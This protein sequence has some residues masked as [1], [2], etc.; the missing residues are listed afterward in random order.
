MDAELRDALQH[1]EAIFRDGFNKLDNKV[2]ALREAVNRRDIENA[3]KMAVMSTSLSATHRR[4][5]AHETHHKEQRGRIAALIITVL[6]SFF[7]S[8]W[9]WIKSGGKS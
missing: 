8:I 9:A 2:D 6:G 1:Q 7:A 5:D 4:L 3:E